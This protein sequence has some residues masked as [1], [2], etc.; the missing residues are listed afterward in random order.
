MLFDPF[1]GVLVERGAPDFEAGRRAE[2]VEYARPRSAAAA[3]SVNEGGCFVPARVAGKPQK[4]QSYLRLADRPVFLAGLGAAFFL[5]GLALA[6]GFAA[7]LAGLTE[8][9][10]VSAARPS[11]GAL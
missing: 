5:A 4:W 2:P 10:R 9:L 6:F 1:D 8:A 7:P 11:A 3:A